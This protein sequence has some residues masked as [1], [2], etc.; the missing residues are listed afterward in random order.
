MHEHVSQEVVQLDPAPPAAAAPVQ[1][2]RLDV[3]GMLALQRSAGNRAATRHLQRQVLAREAPYEVALAAE[4]AP[5]LDSD[6]TAPEAIAKL[7]G[8]WIQ[9]MVFEIKLLVERHGKKDQLIK[10]AKTRPRVQ[11]ALNT[12]LN[13]DQTKSGAGMDGVVADQQAQLKGFARRRDWLTAIPKKGASRPAELD[14]P[15]S[16]LNGI[17]AAVWH[18]RRAVEDTMSGQWQAPT[19]SKD[20]SVPQ[21]D[22]LKKSSLTADEVEAMSLADQHKKFKANLRGGYM[23]TAAADPRDPTSYAPRGTVAEAD[24]PRVEA[25]NKLVWAELGHEGD[26]GS[27]NTYDDAVLTW[28]K[29]WAASGRLPKLMEQLPQNLKDRLMDLGFTYQGGHWYALAVGDKCVL[30]DADALQYLRFNTAILSA[31]Y[32]MGQGSDAQG[33]ADAQAGVMFTEFDKMPSEIRALD[34]RLIQVIVHCCWWGHMTMGKAKELT[35]GVT[36]TTEQL[37]AVVRWQAGHDSIRSS[38]DHGANVVT[39]WQANL[40]QKMGGGV[41]ESTFTE[42]ADAPADAHSGKTL[43]KP[44]NRTQYVVV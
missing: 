2:A 33:L 22:R 13:P 12:V 18:E 7:D 43:I 39:G 38:V 19:W 10:F 6:T 30:Q 5:K 1:E 20:A 36:G 16:E 17:I 3:A 35:S 37:R 15:L 4:L 26:V 40:F 14:D 44:G 9:Y 27:I 29:G 23:K 32:A 24:R 21:A 34:D 42:R 41:I 25:I 8:E 11:A 31:M 28:G